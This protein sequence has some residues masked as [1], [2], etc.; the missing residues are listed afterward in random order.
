MGKISTRKRG[1]KWHFS[2]E[3]SEVGSKRKRVEKG[4]FASQKEAMEAGVSHCTRR[5]PERQYSINE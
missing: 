2:F 3:A 5:L 1:E 4:V